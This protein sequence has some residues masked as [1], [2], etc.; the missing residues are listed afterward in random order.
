MNILSEIL[1]SRVRADIFQQLFDYRCQ[2]LHMRA[3]ERKSC[4]TF[5]SIRQELK[6]LSRLDLVT[7]RRDGNRLYYK[8][9]TSHPLHAIL[10]E[11]VTKTVGFVALL[12]MAL[13]HPEIQFAFIFGS[14]T[15]N[16]EIAESDLDIVI[17]GDLGLREFSHLISGQ[18]EQIGREINPQIY[19]REE[20][21]KRRAAGDHLISKILTGE[22]IFII[23]T[24]HELARI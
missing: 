9:N 23:G 20:F 15:K 24:E 2:E 22:K 11:L 12:G 10:L 17:I 21:R 18:E 5:N 19:S 8:A 1:S 16:K 4:V 14:Q 7:S 6:R 3:I 13:T